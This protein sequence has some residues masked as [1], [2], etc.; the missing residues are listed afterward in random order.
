MS[1][2]AQAPEGFTNPA[3]VDLSV[4]TQE[5]KQNLIWTA[6]RDGLARL[7]PWNIAKLSL[8]R[9]KGVLFV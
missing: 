9:S 1:L 5:M 2:G 6:Q 8:E 3:G 7:L 4:S